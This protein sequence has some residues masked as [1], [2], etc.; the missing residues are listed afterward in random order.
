RGTNMVRI[1]NRN[2]D[3][4]AFA[5]LSDRLQLDPLSQDRPLFGLQKVPQPLP[6]AF[7]KLLRDQQFRDLLSDC[8]FGSVTESLFG[9]RVEIAD[10]SVSVHRDDAV[11]GG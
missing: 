4:E 8:L 5:S 9:G 2:L 6:M 10:Q 1:G 7:P 11:E 3:R